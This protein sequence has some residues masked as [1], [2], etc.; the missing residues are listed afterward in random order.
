MGSERGKDF[1]KCFGPNSWKETLTLL[2]IEKTLGDT[3]LGR[4][5]GRVYLYI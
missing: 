2:E 5:I 1:S 4:K 3:D